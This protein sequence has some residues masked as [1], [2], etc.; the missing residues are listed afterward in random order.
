MDIQYRMYEGKLGYENWICDLTSEN[1]QGLIPYYL[2]SKGDL[3]ALYDHADDC[4]VYKVLQV[5][6]DCGFNDDKE[7]S[8]PSVNYFVEEYDWEG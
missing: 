3:I 8:P 6:F 2:P 7:T 4:T 5:M 1:T